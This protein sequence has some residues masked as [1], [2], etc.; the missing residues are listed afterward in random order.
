MKLKFLCCFLFCVQAHFSLSAQSREQIERANKLLD[1]FNKANLKTIKELQ[2]S[3]PH[4]A[5]IL[6]QLQSSM[7]KTTQT[8]KNAQVLM[9]KNIGTDAI[10]A[11]PQNHPDRN[12]NTFTIMIRI[13][14]SK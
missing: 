4:S 1:S 13:T 7:A 10:S 12:I 8:V 3:D 6:Q 14:L 2:K 5:T 11:L 9:S